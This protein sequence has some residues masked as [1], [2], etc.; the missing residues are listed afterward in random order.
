MDMDDESLAF[1]QKNTLAIEVD[2]T[3]ATPYLVTNPSS[4]GLIPPRRIRGAGVT[5]A[6]ALKQFMVVLVTERGEQKMPLA[7]YVKEA[8]ADAEVVTAVATDAKM[9]PPKVEPVEELPGDVKPVVTK[10][11]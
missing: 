8:T 3:D 9:P 2:F 10:E 5:L 11:G 6:D 7:E 1:C 4:I